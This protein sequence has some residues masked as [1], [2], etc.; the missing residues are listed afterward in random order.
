VWEAVDRLIDRARGWPD[1]RAHRLHLL[2]ARRFRALGQPVPEDVASDEAIAGVMAIA[3]PLVLERARDA[4]GQPL[5]V[6]KG[7]EVA[8]RYPDP[9][10]RSFIDLDLLVADPDRAQAALLAAG[11][12]EAP[13]PPW[14]FRRR[15]EDL[16]AGR[17][18]A[19][20]LYIPGLPLRLELHRRPSW[21]RWLEPPATEPLLAAAVPSA[22]GVEGVLTLAPLHH[23]PILAAHSWVHEPLGRARDLLDLVLVADGLDRGELARVAHSLGIARL[24][25]ATIACADALL[26][27]DGRRTSAQRIWARNLASVRERTVLEAHVQNWVSCLWTLPPRQ[28]VRQAAR[29][30]L[31]DLRPAAEEPWRAKLRRSA[32]AVG[33]AFA[34][35]SRHDEGLGVEA[36]QLHPPKRWSRRRPRR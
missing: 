9:A 31:W 18:H 34:R 11:F 12:E 26:S 14:A 15:D 17:H 8:A 2:A 20:P 5:V 19:R 25:N 35:K 30:V 29:N 36:R 3:T 1:L 24:W 6:L 27:T 4:S 22:T 33:H 21:P 13:D 28:G 10:L 16:F 7:P 32:R 23:A